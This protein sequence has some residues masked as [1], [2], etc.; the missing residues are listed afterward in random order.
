MPRIQY[1]RAGMRQMASYSRR[2]NPNARKSSTPYTAHMGSPPT[3][4]QDVGYQQ[5]G[6]VEYVDS[7]AGAL[8]ISLLP[9]NAKSWRD[10]S[11]AL[12]F[13]PCCPSYFFR[14]APRTQLQFNLQLGS[15]TDWGGRQFSAVHRTK[16]NFLIFAM[17][18]LKSSP[19]C[20]FETSAQ[21]VHRDRTLSEKSRKKK[22]PRT[23][24]VLG[25]SSG[26][27]DRI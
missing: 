7:K 27:G 1:R 11:G 2:E 24:T 22:I 17:P 16:L 14:F 13:I 23:V 18:L 4:E 21:N 15:S 26:C 3:G 20:S 25:K 10:G 6:D 9:W 8:L 19:R 12:L 5:D